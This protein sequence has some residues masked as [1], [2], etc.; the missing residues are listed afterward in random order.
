[1]NEPPNQ[2]EWFIRAH[3]E[4]DSGQWDWGITQFDHTLCPSPT[5]PNLLPNEEELTIRVCSGDYSWSFLVILAMTMTIN[6]NSVL[7]IRVA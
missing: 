1:M 2:L 7:L 5:V 6:S 3:S 4:V